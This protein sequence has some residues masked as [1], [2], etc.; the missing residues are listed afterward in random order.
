MANLFAAIGFDITTEEAY[1]QQAFAA[2]DAGARIELPGGEYRRWSPGGGVEL[3]VR[4]EGRQVVGMD[5]HLAG[6]AAIR[7]GVSEWFQDPRRSSLDG[8]YQVWADPEDD[9]PESGSTTFV[10]SAPDFAMHHGARL[11]SIAPVQVAAFALHLHA[12]DDET[13]FNAGR[14]GQMG[15]AVESLAPTGMFGPDLTPL[16]PPRPEAHL[17]GRV[18]ATEERTNPATG[19]PFRWARVRTWGGEMEI[20]A[21]PALVEGEVREGG[22]VSGAFWMSGRVRFGEG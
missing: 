18:L 13:A 8:M 22:I 9:D 15:Y 4:I 5:P 21:E 2:A 6:G 1:A 7:A 19:N 11:P 16:D 20:V 10:V 3:W 12:F 14:T 17:S